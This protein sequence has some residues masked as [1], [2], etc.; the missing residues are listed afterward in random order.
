MIQKNNLNTK[1]VMLSYSLTHTIYYKLSNISIRTKPIKKHHTP[2]ACP[3]K[4]TSNSLTTTII[5]LPADRANSQGK[6]PAKLT[7]S[8]IPKHAKTG[9]T[10]PLIIPIKK[11]FFLDTPLALIGI[12]TAKP[13]GKF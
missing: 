13:S 4:P 5:I 10:T 6:T 7:A 1:Y 3:F 2:I 9:S 11:D 8:K 12:L